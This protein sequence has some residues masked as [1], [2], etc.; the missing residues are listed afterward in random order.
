MQYDVIKKIQDGGWTPYWKSFLAISRRHI[1]WLMRNS[2]WRRSICFVA[3]CLIGRD[4]NG[5]FRKFKMADSRHVENSFI[6]I[7]QPRYQISIK[8]GTR[9]QFPFQGWIF[10]KKIK[11]FRIQDGERT[12]YWKWFWGYIWAP[13]WPINAKFGSEMKNHRPI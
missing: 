3:Y 11:F 5:N 12:P 1:G 13:Y 7:Y 10:E 6:T 2:D 9:T 8:F 4:Q